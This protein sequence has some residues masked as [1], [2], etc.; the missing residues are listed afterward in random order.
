MVPN[1]VS[2]AA[3]R[4]RDTAAS[5]GQAFRHAWYRMRYVMIATTRLWLM[6]W[7]A[8]PP[9][10]LAVMPLA[11]LQIS[12]SFGRHDT[13]LFLRFAMLTKCGSCNTAGGSG[14]AQFVLVLATA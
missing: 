12:R 14:G 11:D 8:A 6:I 2:T 5:S 1:R 4:N 7:L 13:P 10:A 9:Q 3:N